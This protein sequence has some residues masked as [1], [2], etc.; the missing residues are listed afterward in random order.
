MG[1]QVTGQ[2]YAYDISAAVNIA[3]LEAGDIIAIRVLYSSVATVTNIR[4]L[5]ARLKE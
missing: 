4:L 1:A 2:L 3:P 5:G